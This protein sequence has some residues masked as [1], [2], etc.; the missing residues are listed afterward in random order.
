MYIQSTFYQ[1]LSFLIEGDRRYSFQAP[2]LSPRTALV[3]HYP[4]GVYNAEHLPI[5][6]VDY[7]LIEYAADLLDRR[8]LEIRA[9]PQA[10][11]PDE[12]AEPAGIRL[13]RKLGNCL[14][15]HEPLL[16]TALDEWENNWARFQRRRSALINE[17]E[18]LLKQRELEEEVA[19]KLG[20]E[21]VAGILKSQ[22]AKEQPR[23]TRIEK[24]EEGT[25]AL[26]IDSY[27]GSQEVCAGSEQEVRTVLEGYEF[28]T[29][30]V[31]LN[32]RVQPVSDAYESLKH[33]ITRVED[34]IDYMTLR[35]R[36]DGRCALCPDQPLIEAGSRHSRAAAPD[37]FAAPVQSR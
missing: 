33:S 11:S 7:R 21:V 9:K 26:L 27:S 25:A 16:Q 5:A 32:Q 12:I 22:L 14:L 18:N 28:V 10:S 19:K 20:Q 3:V 30:Q 35:G 29:R 8:G 1:V 2:Q 36:P 31:S 34:L 23:S 37:Y 15:E 4:S 13:A 6:F 24:R 17:A